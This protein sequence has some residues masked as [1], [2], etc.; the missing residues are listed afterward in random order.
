MDDTATA[1]AAA[2]VWHLW[3]N[4]ERTA[5]L[6]PGQRPRTMREGWKIQRALDLLAGPRIGWK[7]AATSAAGQQHIGVAAPLVG[8]LYEGAVLRS[9]ATTAT[10]SVAM[11]EPEFAFRLARDLPGCEDRQ[12]SREEVLAATGEVIPAIEVPNSRFEK[13]E[14]IGGPRLV[15]EAVASHQIVLGDPLVEWDPE[16]LPE[17]EVTVFLNGSPVSRGRGA[18]VLGDPVEA[19]LWLANELVGNGAGL[20]RGDI[21]M[22]G[23]SASPNVVHPGDRVLA[24]FGWLGLVAVS[25]AP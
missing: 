19:L 7:I 2:S 5:D 16:R 22:T 11:T 8:A 12:L 13:F 25:F 18:D 6:P 17:Q 1:A 4:G 23:A 10:T 3:Q 24:D 9:G 21:V 14:S 20:Q 15:A